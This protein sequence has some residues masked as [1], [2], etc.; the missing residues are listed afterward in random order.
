MGRRGLLKLSL[1]VLVMTL[2]VLL[3]GG[4]ALAAF[5]DVPSDHWAAKNIYKMHARGVVAGYL[6]GTFKP[7]ET[8][9]QVE[10][11]V[12][13]VRTMGLQASYF[14]VLPELPFPVPKWAENEVRLA[15]RQGLLKSTDQFDANAGATRAWVARLLVRV[16]GKESQ[17]EEEGLMPNF[18]DMYKI[19]AWA[20]KYVRVAQ[21][22][23]LITGYGDNTFRPDR[24]V[25]RAEMVTLLGRAEKHLPGSAAG[26]VTG[27][28]VD[29]SNLELTVAT[30]DG[31]NQTF[32]VT[33]A[34]VVYVGDAM[35]DVTTLQR[36]D[37]VRLV[38]AGSAVKYVEKLEG[39]QVARVVSGTV[40]KVYPELNAFVVEEAGGTLQ[41]LYLPQEATV[42]VIGSQ[43]Q[44]LDA[45]QPGNRVEVTLNAA[46]Y[47]SGIVVNRGPITAAQ[48][49]GV[50]YDLD[51]QA[52][53]L[54]LQLAGG[55]LVS[56]PLA[57]EIE[58]QAGGAR[59]PT[60]EDV[61]EGDRVRVEV[62]NGRVTAVE[63]LEVAARLDVRGKVVI[64]DADK[65]VLVL[66]ADSDLQAYRLAPGVEVTVPGLAT[67]F[68]SDI[69]EGDTVTVG[70][71]DGE[72]V[73]L[74]V[75]GRQVKD[76]LSAVIFAVDTTNRV[77]TFKNGNGSLLAYEVRDEARIVVNDRESSLDALE[78]DM[79]VNFRLLDGE[80]IYL[81]TDNTPGGTVVSLDEDGYLLVLQ[82]DS[83]ERKTY[84]VDD[85][86]DVD[87]ED[88][89]NEFDEIK[90]GDYVEIVVKDGLVTEINLRSTVTYRVTDV[91]E[92]YNRL[93]VEDEDGDS[94]RLYIRSGVDLVV[95]GVAY[96]DIDDVHDGDLVRA[97]YIGNDLQKVEVLVP[98]R[99][100]ITALDVLQKKVTLRLFNG[101]TTTVDFTSG[102][103]VKS[104][105]KT[106][107]TFSS[108]G[109]KDR[110]E[111]L[112]N[113]DGG[114]TFELMDE[115]TGRLAVDMEGDDDKLFL[116]E[117]SMWE[118]YDLYEGVYIHDASGT[119]L[120]ARDLDRG[121][122]V[123][124][125]LL[126]GEVYEIVKE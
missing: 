24:Y 79:E 93:K 114:Y 22:Y 51:L 50:V 43:A 52:E 65:D 106:Y 76:S 113:L 55:Q 71:D 45:L 32:N 19:P 61:R 21:D 119:A 13:A 97:T 77:I 62:E 67:A 85:D 109:L 38:A 74:A 81:E 26:Y 122:W 80:I 121:D 8:V 103:K 91:N 30:G 16:I 14:G 47:V 70:I 41:T 39:Q 126:R 48:N 3:W 34:T 37:R 12:M 110:V 120:N 115:V 44:G 95:P 46:G 100:E 59:F 90:K 83:G 66:E 17:A 57:P 89:R 56:Y 53:L 54:T 124:L 99:G 105:S 11:V 1:I 23:E 98:R 10:A 63:V 78:Q 69:S 84:I 29:V 58:V 20:V 33:P 28:V 72:V 15:L 87:S 40:K 73:S 36:F 27:T 125:Y 82:L 123:R 60:L 18:A 92:S 108:L 35:T 68:L 49:E 116:E 107:D 31:Q 117:G 9:T 111:V 6:D 25:T 4:T 2:S 7:G 94:E 96:P 64:L 86:V 102:S 104:G 75:E 5:S 101:A 42:S 118:D 88:G 112:E